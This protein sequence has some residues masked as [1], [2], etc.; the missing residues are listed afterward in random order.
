MRVI[1]LDPADTFASARERLLNGGPGRVVLVLTA[2][3]DVFRRGVDL[4]LLRRVADR[5]RL[6]VGVVTT[7]RDVARQAR[8][9]GLPA[10]SS[11]TL[12][13][14]YRPGWWRGRRRAERVGFA[15]GDDRRSPE[16][17][18]VEETLSSRA[19]RGA[20]Q[21][22]V[23]LL[24]V[25]LLGLALLAAA[26]AYVLPHATITLRPASQPVQAIVD[27]A[28]DPSATAPDIAGRVVPA[29]SVRLAVQ[30]E[31]TG[32]G[33]ATVRALALQGLGTAAAGMLAAR[34]DPGESLVPASAHAEV[35]GEQDETDGGTT[36]ITLDADLEGLAVATADV[37]TVVYGDLAAALPNG[38][39]PDPAT[40][41]LE[42]GPVSAAEPGRFQV[43]AR[44]TGRAVLDG[45]QLAGQLAGQSLSAAQAYLESLPLAEP[46][47]VDVNPGWWARRLAHLPPRPG[48]IEVQVRP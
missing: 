2:Q 20:W 30:W 17:I 44:A 21:W 19:R 10:F 41:R 15:P 1:E 27:L 3:G 38:L 22:P 32:D 12:A 45:T 46:A 6:E 39:T 11:V 42:L 36:R 16:Q 25:A 47:A 28:A 37:M 31:A 18:A 26:A 48:H 14:H 13:E 23:A 34:L 8:A 4:V 33:E 5:E 40:V 7:D 9:L 24:A 35:T 29:R 43:T